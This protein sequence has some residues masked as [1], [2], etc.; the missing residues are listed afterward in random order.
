LL[1]FIV[2]RTV[3][4]DNFRQILFILPP[5]FF[6]AGIAFEKIKRPATQLAVIALCVLPG[7]IG[8]VRL[9]PYEYIYYNSFIGGVNG[10][11]D[12][13]EM[14]YWGTSF[15]EAA[16]YVSS[17]A[18]PN[19]NVWIEGPTQSFSNYGREDLHLFSSHENLRAE[20]YDYIVV[21]TRDHIDQVTYP[22]A[23]VVYEVTRGKAI[24]AVV[25]QP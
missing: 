9:H 10:A 6:M 2:A 4:Y 5:V 15:R 13:F 14:D 17:V 8:I 25:K 18:R 20:H 7:I 16:N 23:K 12:K 11:A 21:T 24:L 19:A 1:G 3:L 22:G